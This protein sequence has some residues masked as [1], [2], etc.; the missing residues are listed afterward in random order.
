MGKSISWNVKK[1]FKITQVTQTPECFD[2]TQRKK[3]AAGKND[4][5][6]K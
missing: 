3:I 1:P 5:R 2:K 6:F 4:F